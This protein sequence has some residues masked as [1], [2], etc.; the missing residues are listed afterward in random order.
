MNGVY[1]KQPKAAVFHHYSAPDFPVMGKTK[2][3][4]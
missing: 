2:K 1:L 4:I 3:K